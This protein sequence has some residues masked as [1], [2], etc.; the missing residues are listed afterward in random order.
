[1]LDERI[2][3]SNLH[4]VFADMGIVPRCGIEHGEVQVG[5]DDLL[6]LGVRQRNELVGDLQELIDT[7]L[8]LPWLI[9]AVMPFGQLHPKLPLRP[10]GGD[11]AIISFLESV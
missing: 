8:A 10:C 3:V 1:M 6:V 9:R 7:Q 2:M 5:G 4:D 11:V